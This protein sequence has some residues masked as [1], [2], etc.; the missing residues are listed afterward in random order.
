MWLIA[1][2]VVSLFVGEID[3][4]LLITLAAGLTGFYL[5]LLI[6][7]VILLAKKLT[8]GVLQGASYTENM[9]IEW[10]GE[11]FEVEIKPLTNKEASE[12]Q[13]MAQEGINIKGKPGRGGKMEQH[14]DMDSKANTI[15]RFASDVKVVALGTTDESLTEKVVEKEFPRKLV[16]DIS[17]RIR[18]ISGISKEDEDDERIKDFNEGKENPRDSDRE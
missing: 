11:E 7:G 16:I 3:F 6:I 9:Q 2:T 8:A 13:A 15:A 1:F 12:V 10:Q 17:T 14:M 18:E 4:Y 5:N